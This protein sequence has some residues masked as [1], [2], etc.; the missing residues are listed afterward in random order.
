MRVLLTNDDGVH[1]QG[2]R[3]LVE[4]FRPHGEV[5]VVAPEREQS[6]QS[7]A[8]TLHKPLR[9]TEIGPRTLALSGTPADCAYAAIHGLIPPPD[10]VVSGVNRGANLGFDVHYSGTVAAAREAALQ[11]KPALA[12][13]LVL[14][15][16][17]EVRHL[18]TAAT[19]A[20]GIALRVVE[21]GLP[22]GTFLNLNVPD[23]SDVPGIRAASL[24]HARYTAA[25]E[26]RRDPRGNR[27]VWIGG[28]PLAEAP[29][30]GTDQAWIRQGWATLT[31][32][33]LDPTARDLLEAVDGW[34]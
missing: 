28:E 31:P 8:F 29:A 2:L 10:V 19:L 4:A 32:L 24:G 15:P 27:Y 1:A 6:A 13:S 26:E 25:V 11:G 7:H 5:W 33:C 12:V 22:A 23:R 18:D 21:E 34:C 30:P 16:G 3:A 9:I 14:E 17:K 20:V